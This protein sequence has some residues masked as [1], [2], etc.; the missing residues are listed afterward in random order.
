MNWGTII[1]WVWKVVNKFIGT[2]VL[3][4]LPYSFSLSADEGNVQWEEGHTESVIS[5]AT[6]HQGD[7]VGQSEMDTNENHQGDEVGQSEMD[8]N[9]NHQGDEV[10]QSEMDTNENHQGDEVGQSEAQIQQRDLASKKKRSRKRSAN[11][12]GR[13][14]G[15]RKKRFAVPKSKIPIKKIERRAM[16][17]AEP[18][19]QFRKYFETGTDEAEL[20]SVINQEIKQLFNLLKTT[21]RRDLRL[22]LGNLYVEKARL[23]EYRL[24][25]EYDRKM[26]MFSKGQLK[27]E[28]RYESQT[29]LCVCK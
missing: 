25:E 19:P 8:T 16:R 14:F 7:E 5:D 3:C 9:E 2:L 13:R 24:Y 28:T 1:M 15:V 20:E 12:K 17:V 27:R 11:R 23:I 22:R 29:H 18:P 10:G 6:N 21:K 26:E 4:M